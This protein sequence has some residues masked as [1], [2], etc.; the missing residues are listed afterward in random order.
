VKL[1]LQRWQCR[2]EGCER[3]TFTAQLPEVAAPRARRTERATEI[4][5]LLGHG[6]G[7]RLGERLIK[8][9]GMPT[10]S[11]RDLPDLDM[12]ESAKDRDAEI[13]PALDDALDDAL[14]LRDD[15]GPEDEAFDD[16]VVG[17]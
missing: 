3:K 16:T 15:E 2:N 9:I 11:L 14:G 4:V 13:E 12:L 6:L 7:R 10:S 1:R 8:R 5:Y 17:A